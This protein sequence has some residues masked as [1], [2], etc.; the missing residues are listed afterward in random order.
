MA[1]KPKKK[2]V[3]RSKSRDS[4]TFQLSKRESA[5]LKSMTKRAKKVHA[6]IRA[7]NRSIERGLERDEKLLRSIE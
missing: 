6:E 3:G 4:K 5:L 1:R 2:P 7:L